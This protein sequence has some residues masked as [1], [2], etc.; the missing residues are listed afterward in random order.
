MR[1]APR[2]TGPE[3]GAGAGAGDGWPAGGPSR[4]ARGMAAASIAPSRRRFAHDPLT[5]FSSPGNLAG[6]P[7]DLRVVKWC[8]LV[9]DHE[10]S[11]MTSPTHTSWRNFLTV[12]L[13]GVLPSSNTS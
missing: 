11:Q 7:R 6:C 1:P 5:G 13:G 8:F 2:R 10:A 3:G 9:V 12:V 4:D